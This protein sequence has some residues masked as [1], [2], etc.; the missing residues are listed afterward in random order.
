[1]KQVLAYGTFISISIIMF[2]LYY[3]HN[4]QSVRKLIKQSQRNIGL[5]FRKMDGNNNIESKIQIKK[6]HQSRKKLIYQG[7]FKLDKHIPDVK[8]HIIIAYIP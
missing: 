5:N 3:G 8:F 6:L 2:L 1:M 7:T 4:I